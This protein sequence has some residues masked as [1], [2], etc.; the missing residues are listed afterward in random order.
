[1]SIARKQTDVAQ[2]ITVNDNEVSVSAL[3]DAT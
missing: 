3:F 1:L 2:W